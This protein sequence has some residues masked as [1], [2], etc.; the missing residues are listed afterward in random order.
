MKRFVSAS[1]RLSAL[2]A[3]AGCAS[4]GGGLMQAQPAASVQSYDPPPQ[5]VEA[6]P[7]APSRTAAGPRL[8]L[9]QGPGGEELLN[10]ML[11]R[12][13]AKSEPPFAAM[14]APTQPDPERCDFLARLS[15]AAGA[16]K[17]ELLSASDRATLFK[18]EAKAGPVAG[19]ARLGDALYEAALKP[20]D[21][22]APQPPS[23]TR[24][25]PPPAPVKASK[26]YDS[27][28]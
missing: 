21:A 26:E 20:A 15:G 2:L 19:A 22:A 27:Q 28:L 24:P 9:V 12:F 25:A 3:L 6:P 14:T 11:E 18:A 8:C 16:Q 10:A 17:A 7:A 4:T 1:W 5:P 23:S 13:M